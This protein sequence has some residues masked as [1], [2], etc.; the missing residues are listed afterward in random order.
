MQFQQFKSAQKINEDS[1]KINLFSSLPFGLE[2][3]KRNFRSYSR[4]NFSPCQRNLIKT[5][6]I[7]ALIALITKMAL[8]LH[9]S[10]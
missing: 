7:K 1:F 3:E 6:Q 5:F 9:D 4:V 8:I 10:F 2:Y